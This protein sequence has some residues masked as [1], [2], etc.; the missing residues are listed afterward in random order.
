VLFKVCLAD[1]DPDENVELGFDLIEESL[2]PAS[3]V[4]DEF[5]KGA[6]FFDVLW[7]FVGVD[8]MPSSSEKYMS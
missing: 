8:R 2:N 6:C 7:F 3:T 1:V 4:G 5:K